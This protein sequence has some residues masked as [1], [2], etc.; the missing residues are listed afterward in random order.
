MPDLASLF[1]KAQRKIERDHFRQ[2]KALMLAE[3]ERTQAQVEMGLDPY[4]DSAG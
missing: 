1:Y 3:K 2:R 4:L